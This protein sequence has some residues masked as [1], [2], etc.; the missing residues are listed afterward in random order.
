MSF[1]TD[2][3][4]DHF[5]AYFRGGGWTRCIGMNE[6]WASFIEPMGEDVED[7]RAHQIINYW[8]NSKQNQLA[9]GALVYHSRLSSDS[10]Q[11]DNDVQMVTLVVANDIADLNAEMVSLS[12]SCLSDEQRNK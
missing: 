11:P 5:D 9:M 12:I 1:A 6:E 8:A 4:L 2:D 10:A 7:V 3:V